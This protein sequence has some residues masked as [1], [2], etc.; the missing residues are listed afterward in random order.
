[1]SDNVITLVD[2]LAPSNSTH[3]T[4]V[5]LVDVMANGGD[6]PAHPAHFVDHLADVGPRRPVLLTGGD[7]SAPPYRAL[8]DHHLISACRQAGLTTIPAIVISHE[9]IQEA[10]TTLSERFNNIEDILERA[11]VCD[12]VARLLDQSQ[13]Q[14]AAKLA[15]SRRSLRRYRSLRDLHP[16]ALRLLVDGKLSL[17]QALACDDAPTHRRA[18]LALTAAK[19]GLSRQQTVELVDR[20]RRSPDAELLVLLEE[21]LGCCPRM[22]ND[23]TSGATEAAVETSESATE[24]AATTSGSDGAGGP[25]EPRDTQDERDSALATGDASIPLTR[26]V[27]MTRY[28]SQLKDGRRK[29]LEQLAHQMQLNPLTVRRAALLLIADPRLVVPSA[30]AYARHVSDKGLGRAV[31]QMELALARMQA[32]ADEG[33]TPNERKV[34]ELILHHVPLWAEELMSII[35]KAPTSVAA[36]SSSEQS[37]SGRSHQVD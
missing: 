21:M 19:Y 22:A 37:A 26:N 36:A 14:L 16:A 9:I 4:L 7:D 31:A 25:E 1:M 34:L 11:W 23:C 28:T 24:G 3:P 33:V 20:A 32:A 8:S 35:Q 2:V 12:T 15:I 30:V 27:D 13:D 18:E 17:T 29:A 10:V 6:P 5:P